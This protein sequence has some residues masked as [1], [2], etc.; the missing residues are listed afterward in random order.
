[1]ALGKALDLG[2]APSSR[3]LTLL[4]REGRI[5]C[6]DLSGSFDADVQI[7]APLPLGSP[8]PPRPRV[9]PVTLGPSLDLGAAPAA[10]LLARRRK[11]R[12]M[13]GGDVTGALGADL[14]V[15]ADLLE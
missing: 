1:M 9:P 5:V 2:A 8:L 11:E 15:A 6:S 12:R 13:A 3:L 10:R 14:E 4:A 7:A